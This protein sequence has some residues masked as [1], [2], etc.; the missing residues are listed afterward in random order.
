M[1]RRSSSSDSYTSSLTVDETR[2]FPL[3]GTTTDISVSVVE[4]LEVEVSEL[5][6]LAVSLLEVE[7]ESKTDLLF[8]LYKHLDCQSVSL[9]FMVEGSKTNS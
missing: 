6:V 1:F 8:W 7:V 4:M 3:E 2:H 5:E 9:Y